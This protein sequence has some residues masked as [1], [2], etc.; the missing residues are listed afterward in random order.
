MKSNVNYFK[1]LIGIAL[2]GGSVGC[3]QG[4]QFT[5]LND[6][7]VV[8]AV[9]KDSSLTKVQL[10]FGNWGTSSRTQLV[11]A[12]GANFVV[13]NLGA[14]LELECGSAQI[15]G[16]IMI[17]EKGEFDQDGL[18]QS[19]AGAQLVGGNPSIPAHFHGVVSGNVLR[20]DYTINGSSNS[21]SL[22]LTLGVFARL[23]KCYPPVA[24]I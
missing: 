18:F 2:L 21:T 9:S 16:D 10:P 11:E 8:N 15:Q 1:I 17:N 13:S 14:N 23:L 6:N 4:T 12:S 5:P 7:S 24:N 19:E 20:L 3:Q 22:Q